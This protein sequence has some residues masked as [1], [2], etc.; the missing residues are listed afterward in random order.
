MIYRGAAGGQR[1]D[2][3]R[4]RLHQHDRERARRDRPAPPAAWR[5]G[6]LGRTA[7]GAALDDDRINLMQWTLEQ[8]KIDAAIAERELAA[9]RSQLVVV[10]PGPLPNRV[11]GVN[12]A[13]FAKQTHQRGRRAALRPRRSAARVAGRRQLRPLPR[14]RRGAA[15]LPG[16]RRAAS[17]TATASTRTATASPAAGTRRPTARSTERSALGCSSGAVAGGQRRAD[18]RRA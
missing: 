14:R 15:R 5:V 12:I 7:P 4:R 18:A 3:R 16:R 11:E 17:A 9:A 1:L 10:Q 2:R 8:Q 6:R 13:L